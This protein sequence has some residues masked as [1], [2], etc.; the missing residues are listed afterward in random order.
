[1]IL[2]IVLMISGL[3]KNSKYTVDF[4][5]DQCVIYLRAFLAWRMYDHLHLLS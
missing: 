5:T 4:T 1:M 3:G 2:E